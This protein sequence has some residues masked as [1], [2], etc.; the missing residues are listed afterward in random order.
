MSE[1][2]CP[3]CGTEFTSGAKFCNKCGCNLELEFI[4]IPTCPVCSNTFPTGTKFCS[5]HGVNLVSPE[6]L[7][8]CCSRCEKQ[9]ADGIK[10]C[11]ECGGSVRVSLK[12]QSLPVNDFVQTM[13][14]VS[15]NLANSLR[16]KYSTSIG[17]LAGIFGVILFSFFN[18]IKITIGWGYSIKANL[19]SIV[20]KLNQSDLRSL[21][22]GSFE[23]TIIRI[24]SVLLMIAMVFAF[25]MLITSLLTKPH[26]KAKQTLSYSG[27]GLF[28]IVSVIFIVAM[29]F[30]S[31]KVEQWILTVFP[32]LTFSIAILEM[33]FAIPTKNDYGNTSKELGLKYV[34]GESTAENPQFTQTTNLPNGTT[35]LVLGIVS[36]AT[37]WLFSGIIGI[38]TGIIG[39]VKGNKD[40]ILYQRSPDVYSKSSFKNIKTGKTCS[41]IGLV[42]SALFFIYGLR[43]LMFLK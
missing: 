36:I 33:K 2:I 21:L 34:F 4:E 37:C 12:N 8:P 43:F 38:V 23:F 16:T 20:G 22:G 40:M 6:Q 15:S 41:I 32:F 19:F 35:V 17:V 30:V 9:Y 28:A 13:T 42:L 1:L 5:E 31:V 24:V 18:W 25:V 39:F 3:K 14:D 10:F 29:L 11:P 7:I 27:F 26:L